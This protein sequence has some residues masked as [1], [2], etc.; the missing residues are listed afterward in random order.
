[1]KPL[2]TLVQKDP[3]GF[4]VQREILLPV[5]GKEKLVLI[6][7][8][9]LLLLLPPHGGAV[10][11]MICT[12]SWTL[13]LPCSGACAPVISTLW[14]HGYSFLRLISTYLATGPK[15]SQ[16]LLATWEIRTSSS[17]NIPDPVLSQVI[18][19]DLPLPHGEGARYLGSFLDNGLSQCL[20]HNTE[21]GGFFGPYADLPT[22]A[23]EASS[24]SQ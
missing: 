23:S 2:P 5:S 9:V 6:R 22:S 24:A 11:D 13:V 10:E 19:S 15:A 18:S 21:H 7:P 20:R 17:T 14:V 8:F 12:P 3:E 4:S 1:M 16:G